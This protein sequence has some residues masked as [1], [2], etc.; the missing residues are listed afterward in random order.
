MA[1]EIVA[2]RLCQCVLRVNDTGTTFLFFVDQAEAV[3]HPLAVVN[4][5]VQRTKYAP[6]V[7]TD[8]A[9]LM[10]SWLARWWAH[11]ITKKQ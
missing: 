8:M 10:T 4:Y 7:K 1:K 9:A 2:C 6:A 11:L 3:L 5:V